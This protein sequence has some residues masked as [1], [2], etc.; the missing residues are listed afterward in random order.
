[1]KYD[2][3]LAQIKYERTLHL[4]RQGINLEP[5]EYNQLVFSLIEGLK[6]KKSVYVSILESGIDIS[7]S[8]VY[9]YIAEGKVPIKKIDLPYAVTYKKKKEENKRVRLLGL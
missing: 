1:M 6:N 9:K 2:S 3:S 8:T 7:I 4:S 5:S